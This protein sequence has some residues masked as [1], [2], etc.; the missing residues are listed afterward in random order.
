MALK[1]VVPIYNNADKLKRCMD[2]IKN[3][4]SDFNAIII[5]DNSSD[6]TSLIYKQNSDERFTYH[7]NTK[8]MGPLYSRV[9]GADLI[10][11][12]DNDLIITIDGDD[13][14]S[15]DNNIFSEISKKHEEGY[16]VIWGRA[17]GIFEKQDGQIIKKEFGGSYGESVRQKS[18][19]RKYNWCMGFP[20][21]FSYWTLSKVDYSKHFKINGRWIRAATDVAMF[22]PLMEI[23]G[24]K[25]CR[26]DKICYYYHRNVVSDIRDDHIKHVRSNDQK[27]IANWVYKQPKLNVKKQNLR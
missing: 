19:Y 14:L 11:N 17:L 21:C 2:S 8:N 5:D 20:R 16:H 6:D 9:K 3:Q 23:A 7:R 10:A 24:D 26:I 1:V 18:D 25:V 27:A 13:Q 15:E 4:S 12:D 22:I